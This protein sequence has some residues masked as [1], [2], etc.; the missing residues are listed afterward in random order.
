LGAKEETLKA[1]LDELIDE[2]IDYL[3]S[4]RGYS[5]ATIKTYETPLKE[6]IKYSRLYQ[7]G[8]NLTLNIFPWRKSIMQNSKRTIAKKLSAIRSFIKYLNEQRHIRIKLEGDNSIKV[9]K[10]L[11]KPLDESYIFEVLEYADTLQKLLVLLLYGVGLRIGELEGLKRSQIKDDWIIIYGKGSKS[12]QLPL[13]HPLKEALREYYAKYPN[14]EYLFEKGGVAM[15]SFQLRYRLKKLFASRGIK[16]TP[17]QLR[18]SFA[19]HLLDKG[20][21][22]SDISELL[23]HS[24]MA[25]TQIYTKLSSS[26][27]MQEYL[28]S[29]PLAV[30]HPNG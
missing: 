29:H 24:S 13:I 27:K 8:E 20:A 19:T 17:H 15:N 25:T 7:D 3:F 10:T 5:E 28:K 26:K 23:G 11:P 14:G 30:S 1:F 16:A 4:I 6:A 9:P 22:I 21:R 12:R 18:H 2:F